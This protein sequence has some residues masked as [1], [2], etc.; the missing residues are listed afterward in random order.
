MTEAELR[1]KI[2]NLELSVDLPDGVVI[3]G[4][5]M[6]LGGLI[7]A[8]DLDAIL[9]LIHSAEAETIQKIERQMIYNPT[10]QGCKNNYEMMIVDKFPEYKAPEP[11]HIN[12]GPGFTHYDGDNCSAAQDDGGKDDEDDGRDTWDPNWKD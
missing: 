6:T 7:S 5:P 10:C 4:G 8:R 11:H 9:S 12:R 1:K 2:T 3:S